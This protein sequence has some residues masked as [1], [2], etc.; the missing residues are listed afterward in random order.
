MQIKLQGGAT[1]HWAEW[2]SLES[3]QITNAEAWAEKRE[4][5]YTAGGNINWYSHCGNQCGG[6][7]ENQK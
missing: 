4:P 7:L 2:P 3:L 5:S 1:L 6:S